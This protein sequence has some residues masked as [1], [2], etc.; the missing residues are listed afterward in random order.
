L[1]DLYIDWQVREVRFLEV[2]T[3]SYLG[4][5][6][7]PFLVPVEAVMQV[8]EDRFTVEPGRTE[9]VDGPAPFDT[10]V[11]PPRS[12]EWRDD[13]LRLVPI[14]TVIDLLQRGQAT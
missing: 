13:E 8:A 5:G 2:G 12:D 11:A 4:I 10:K 9:K 6:E 14:K 3:G 7:M 1:E